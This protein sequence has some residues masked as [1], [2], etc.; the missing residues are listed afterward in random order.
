MGGR[1]T[2]LTRRS[3][4]PLASRPAVRSPAE[5]A[6]GC[7]CAKMWRPHAGAWSRRRVGRPRRQLSPVASPHAPRTVG[8]QPGPPGTHRRNQPGASLNSWVA[9]SR[10]LGL[11][12]RRAQA[13]CPLSRPSL[14]RWR[15]SVGQGWGGGRRCLWT[16][17]GPH[18]NRDGRPD[19]VGRGCRRGRGRGQSEPRLGVRVC[20]GPR[21]WALKSASAEARAQHLEGVDQAAVDR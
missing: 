2:A 14:M 16:P 5:R 15:A 10:P 12:T 8:Q 21:C 20:R 1:V 18:G 17:P 4:G 11:V 6:S 3:E 19:P 9:V 7:T 13:A